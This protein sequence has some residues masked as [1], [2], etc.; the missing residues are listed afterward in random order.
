MSLFEILDPF[1]TTRRYRVNLSDYSSGIF[2]NFWLLKNARKCYES[3]KKRY[4]WAD[5]EDCLFDRKLVQYDSGLRPVMRPD[6]GILD[7]TQMQPES[8]K[9]K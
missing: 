2:K 4:M 1:D 3:K 7:Y 9:V 5:I 8:E 6:G